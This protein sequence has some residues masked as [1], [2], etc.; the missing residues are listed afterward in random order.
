MGP[1]DLAHIGGEYVSLEKAKAGSAMPRIRLIDFEETQYL[2]P[3]RS[4]Q[5]WLVSL[6]TGVNLA[7]PRTS[8]F[9]DIGVHQHDQLPGGGQPNSDSLRDRHV[10][11][12]V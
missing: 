5:T 7:A 2:L 9:S 8:S 11:E 4:C 6:N 10:E 3:K 12:P 1:H